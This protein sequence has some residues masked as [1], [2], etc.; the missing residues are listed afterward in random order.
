MINAVHEII[1]GDTAYFVVSLFPEDMLAAG[2]AG[3]IV[4]RRLIGKLL[5]W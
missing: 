4:S 5:G 1:Q 2:F 3:G